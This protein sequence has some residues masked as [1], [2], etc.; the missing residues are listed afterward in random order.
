MTGLEQIGIAVF[1]V[2]AIW[3]SQDSREK[4]RRWAPV[5]GLLSQPFW[6]WTTYVNGQ[7]A[8]LALTAFYTVA[9][10]KGFRT[11]W[12][13]PYFDTKRAGGTRT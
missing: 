9:W 7:W 6:A 2:A 1:G 5:C 11:F 8:V 3:L 4:V 10:W 12:L 13:K